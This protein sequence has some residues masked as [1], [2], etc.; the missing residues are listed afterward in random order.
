M[1]GQGISEVMV[2]AVGVAISPV[3]IIALILML[4][5]GRARANGPAFAFGWILGLAALITIVYLITDASDAATDSGASDTTSTIKVVVGALLLVLALRRWRSRDRVAAEP[6]WMHAVETITPV[7]AFGIAVLLAAV[8]PKNLVLTAAA[9][10]GLGQLGIDTSAA[11]VSIVVFVAIASVM[12]VGPV[13]YVLFAGNRAEDE[14]VQLRTWLATNNATVMAV[15]L[16]VF[17]VLLISKGLGLLS[18]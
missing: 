12:I 13:L 11:I 14:L 15:V 2:F 18:V 16:L 1:I 3:P 7:R 8:N 9:G 10:A 6:R 17:G 5:S 4:L